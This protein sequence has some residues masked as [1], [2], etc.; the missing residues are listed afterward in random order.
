MTATEPILLHSPLLSALGVPH[1]FTTRRGG[2]SAG[3]F[4]SL[5]FGN[6]GDLP[7]HDRDPAPNIRSNWDLLKAS[8]ARQSGHPKHE[9]TILE[10]HQVHGAAVMVARRNAPPTPTRP[11]IKAD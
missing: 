5:N 1:A 10:V 3:I 8:L 9:R 4:A 11:D 2:I 6:P 7:P